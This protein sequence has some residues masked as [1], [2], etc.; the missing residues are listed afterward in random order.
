[1]YINQI[2]AILCDLWIIYRCKIKMSRTNIY[3]Y[4]LGI[5]IINFYSYSIG[6][7]ICVYGHFFID[8]IIN[9]LK[10]VEIHKFYNKFTKYICVASSI[11]IFQHHFLSQLIMIFYYNDNLYGNLLMM[12]IYILSRLSMFNMIHIIAICMIFYIISLFLCES[13]TVLF[14]KLDEIYI[15]KPNIVVRM[16]VVK[17]YNTVLCHQPL[18][19]AHPLEDNDQVSKVRKETIR[20]QTINNECDYIILDNYMT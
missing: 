3:A 18:A 19:D 7:F 17:E 1:M 14:F 2:L 20:Q 5:M 9:F 8:I 13:E 11:C 10:D 16:N 6:T 12:A 4:I 15:K